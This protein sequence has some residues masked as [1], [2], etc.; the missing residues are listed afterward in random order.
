MRLFW[1]ILT[2][3]KK[4]L[5]IFYRPDCVTMLKYDSFRP[6]LKHDLIPGYIN[7][8]KKNSHFFSSTIRM[9][10]IFLQKQKKH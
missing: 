5:C 3:I 4:Y 10:R 7:C 8:Y 9:G 2:Y 1:H 6:A